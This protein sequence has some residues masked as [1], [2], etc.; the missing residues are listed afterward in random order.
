[1]TP[2]LGELLP[3]AHIRLGLEMQSKKRVFEAVGVL[4]EDTCGLSRDEVFRMLLERER[5][6]STCLGGEGA[7]P[8]GRMANLT[9]PLCALIRLKKP[10]PYDA[11]DGNMVRTMF[12]LL[13]PQDAKEEHL[14]LLA[15]FSRLDHAGRRGLYVASGPVRRARR[16][17]RLGERIKQL[18]VVGQASGGGGR[19]Q[20]KRSGVTIRLDER[21]LG[22]GQNP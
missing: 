15:A 2:N 17:P 21:A 4:F 6:G 7:I 10:I 8:H 1:M 3:A 22:M 13:A 19:R 9:S 16:R 20:R 5:L 11:E 12:F 14:C 18:R